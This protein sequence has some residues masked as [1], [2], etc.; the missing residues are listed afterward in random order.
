MPTASFCVLMCVTVSLVDADRPTRTPASGSQRSN[1]RIDIH[2]D[3][4]VKRRV[5]GRLGKPMG[6]YSGIR[7]V[8]KASAFSS[9]T[10]LFHITHIDG[11]PLAK[12]IVY[13]RAHFYKSG[14]LPIVPAVPEPEDS[15]VW[16]L[17]VVEHS[18]YYGTPKRFH[19][20]SGIP[21]GVAI[22]PRGV[23]V[24]PHESRPGAIIVPFE[25]TSQ[26]TYPLRP[27]ITKG[28]RVS[29]RMKS[30]KASRYVALKLEANQSK[31]DI[32]FEDLRDRY[33]I[34]GRLGKPLGEYCT[35]RG[36][37]K[38]RRDIKRFVRIF[39]HITHIDGRPVKKTIIYRW[40]DIRFTGILPLGH[41]LQEPK[42]SEVNELR[43]VE[44]VLHNGSPKRSLEESHIRGMG[45]PFKLRSV[46]I[47]HRRFGRS[48]R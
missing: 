27:Q 31:N 18:V 46:L 43:V 17:R 38:A 22:I 4:L 45:F 36:R 39:L 8:W 2:F 23:G 20:E 10:M 34:I 37:W 41:T 15:D 48:A 40:S 19:E 16:E 33:R 30:P 6:E 35:I 32:R 25:L 5:I 7:G 11:R 28:G 21:R 29:R 1:K 47:Y 24:L 42:D 9:R 3:D 44:T 12:E 26:I 13:P 14:G